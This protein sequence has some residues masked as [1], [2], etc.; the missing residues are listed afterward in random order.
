MKN[1]RI[2]KVKIPSQTSKLLSLNLQLTI[3]TKAFIIKK[4]KPKV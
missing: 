1:H 2:F 4:Y 3:K